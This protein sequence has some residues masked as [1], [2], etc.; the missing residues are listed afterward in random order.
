[1]LN[2]TDNGRRQI[3]DGIGMPGQTLKGPRHRL[4]LTLGGVR[5]C[6]K[7]AYSPLQRADNLC[8]DCNAHR[9]SFCPSDGPPGL[10][11]DLGVHRD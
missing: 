7:L 2:A 5:Q 8:F 3:Q 6:L 11:I 1:M 9:H 4:N 10:Q